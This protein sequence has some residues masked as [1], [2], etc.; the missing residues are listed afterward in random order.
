MDTP[1]LHEHYLLYSSYLG[2]KNQLDT[3]LLVA[4]KNVISSKGL[5]LPVISST[6]GFIKIWKFQ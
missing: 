2:R 3:S 4:K 6:T 1:H 5:K